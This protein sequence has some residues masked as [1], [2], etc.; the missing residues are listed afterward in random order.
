MDRTPARSFI[1]RRREYE[2]LATALDQTAGGRPQVVLVGG[3]AG[4]GKT[5]LVE[6]FTDAAEDSG[7]LV[8]SGAC[9]E[10]GLEGLP[11]APII[12]ALRGLVRGLGVDRLVSLLPS[13][14]EL[15][16]LFPELLLP[17]PTGETPAGQARLFHQFAVFVERL[18]AERPVV[19]LIEDLHWADRSTRALL[20][21]LARSLR[22]TRALIVATYR[23][24]NLFRGHPLRPFLAEL[25][26]VEGVQRIELGRFTHAETAELM[27]S[28]LGTEPPPALVDRIFERSGGNAFFVEELVRVWRSGMSSLD[29]SLR[30]LLVS[31]VER[32]PEPAQRVIRLVAIERS[33]VSHQVVAAVAAMP[34]E[35]LL[36]ALRSA[37]DAYVLAADGDGYDFRHALVRE[38]VFDE[39]LPGERIRLHRAYALAL[40]GRPELLPPEHLPSSLAYH[41]AGAGEPT[42]ELPALLRAAAVAK[43]LSAHVEQYQLLR[44]ALDLSAHVPEAADR[45]ELE[46]EAAHAA[47]LAGEH[48]EG[49]VLTEQALAN[50]DRARQPER[51]ALLLARRGRLLLRL[52]HADAVPALEEAVRLVPT[53][54]S[55]TRGT[56]LEILGSALTTRGDAAA[57]SRVSGEAVRIARALGDDELQVAALTTQGTALAYDGRHEDAVTVFEAAR[58]L[59][60]SRNDLPG[61]TRACVNLSVQLWAV[62]LYAEAVT[63]TREGLDAAHK[64]GL[65][66]TLGAFLTANL[67]MAL[68]SMGRWAD[69]AAAMEASEENVSGVFVA[70]LHLLRGDLALARGDLAAA[71][72]YLGLAAGEFGPD[73]GHE[74][75][76][77]PMARLDAEIALREDRIDH[78]RQVLAR[79]LDAAPERGQL[80]VHTWAL[81]TTGAM[82]EVRAR[83]R[84]RAFA[85][86]HAAG[87]L[88][89]VLSAVAARL[90]AD[91]PPWHAY[92][93]QFAA[94]MDSLETTSPAW[95]E[96][97]TA[98]EKAGN[99]HL[100]CHARVR[101]A[102]AAIA[103]RDNRTA[104]ALLASA[105]EEAGALGAGFLQEEIDA[106]ARSVRLPAS[107]ASEA[108]EETRKIDMLGLTPR[109]AEV[110]RLL[111]DGHSNR[112]IG[113]RLFI[114]EKTASVHVS[115]I[116][117]KLGVTSRGEAA[118]TA[119]RLRLFGG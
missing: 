116:L 40:E 118:A 58:V 52:G 112:E 39:F 70:Y 15:A 74:D 64:S 103:L 77:L 61:L 87:S 24:D 83:T 13:L 51:A 31:R 32:L 22:G 3:E 43:G 98:W 12:T 91:T 99:P 38:A 96:V 114:T 71:K 4:V 19:L 11:L 35:A 54:T 29:D 109:E 97:V 95:H 73:F 21:V 115:R 82:V 50:V 47:W 46:Y 84:L 101:A 8:L 18:G 78:A 67:G 30:D 36:D 34:D 72:R 88:T 80:V 5:R 28:A 69:A 23:T 14:P 59:A 86:S 9:V 119:H 65:S 17:G 10:S 56:V 49:L 26:R 42:R 104:R 62:G 79:A 2:R 37:I 48:E 94:E 27:T 20:D 75:G 33:R 105:A 53:G 63:V 89:E 7:A 45:H 76:L 93:A 102:E 57:G 92:A 6:R 107:D 90:P 41:W 25:N 81:V 68:F 1:G 111:T 16:Q 106:L 85:E 44:R 100:A 60:K 108:A 66:A 117:A 110:L 113:A 55:V